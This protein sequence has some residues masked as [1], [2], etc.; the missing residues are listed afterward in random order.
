MKQDVNRVTD[1]CDRIVYRR[2]RSK[3]ERRQS[4]FAR[5]LL[6]FLLN[7]SSKNMK[8]P[9]WF[10]YSTVITDDYGWL[11]AI[12]LDSI[13]PSTVFGFAA[14]FPGNGLRKSARE[15]RVYSR[16]Q[17]DETTRQRVDNVREAAYLLRSRVYRAV[18]KK[19]F[20][21]QTCTVYR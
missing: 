18:R 3:R 12:S 10:K 19:M 6:S 14:T 17:R 13:K 9:F 7:K 16:E 2:E 21:S 5:F 15:K 20:Y 8:N 11:S 1:V 4:Y